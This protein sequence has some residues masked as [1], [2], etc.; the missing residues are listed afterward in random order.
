MGIENSPYLTGVTGMIN[1]RQ[2]ICMKVLKYVIC[3]QLYDSLPLLVHLFI[4]LS[5]Q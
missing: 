1:L 4:Y 2:E 5:I 3:S